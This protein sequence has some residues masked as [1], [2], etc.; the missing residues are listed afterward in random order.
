MAIL[1]EPIRVDT[2]SR[3][4]EGLLVLSDGALVALLVRIADEMHEESQ[5]GSWFVEAAFGPCAGGDGL[6][7]AAVGDAEAWVAD[8]I[9]ARQERSQKPL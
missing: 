7:F 6:L 1:L 3:V 8:C 2:H 5:I 4:E 9:D